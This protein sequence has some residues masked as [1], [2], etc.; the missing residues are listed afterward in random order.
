MA[1]DRRPPAAFSP[2]LNGL[3]ADL[4][5][6]AVGAHVNVD[7]LAPLPEQLDLT[8]SAKVPGAAD[9]VLAAESIAEPFGPKSF[10]TECGIKV[11]GARMVDVFAT[12]AKLDAITPDGQVV[13]IDAIDGAAASVLVTFEG[14]DGALVPCMP[15]F[16]TGLTVQDDELVDI[17]CEP[18]TTNWRWAH[19]A[20]SA[21]EIR[22]LRGIA[23]S[24]A[25]HGRFRI[26]NDDAGDLAQKMQ[27]AKMFD[28]TMAVYAAY[29]YYDLQTVTRIEQMSGALREDL[30]VSLFDVDLLAR[31]LVGRRV[32]I[33]LQIVP[34]VP[35]LSQGWHLL[36]AHGIGLHPALDGIERTMR[37]SLWSLYDGDGVT[38]LRNALQTKEV[39]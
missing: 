2:T 32:T 1:G 19:Y 26:D 4:V 13:R 27:Y 17:A 25:Q 31:G 11:R 37:D 29:A 15:G 9:L 3:S 16:I 6:S 5:R 18:C 12:R 8:R 35:L 36:N 24:S 30:G 20:H 14:G 34:F 22:S 39:R 10:E 33:D 21:D 7:D 23:S 38:K 28:P